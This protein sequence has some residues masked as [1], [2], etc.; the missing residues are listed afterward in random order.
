MRHNRPRTDAERH[1]DAL[2]EAGK[3]RRHLK[4]QRFADEFD[5]TAMLTAVK[6]VRCFDPNRGIP[7][8]TYVIASVLK[9]MRT[10]H[11]KLRL[12]GFRAKPIGTPIVLRI[13]ETHEAKSNDQLDV[14]DLLQHVHEPDRQD[15]LDH[16]FG[17]KTLQEIAEAHGV[18]RQWIHA[19]IQRA[20]RRMR[21]VAAGRMAYGTRSEPLQWSPT[22]DRNKQGG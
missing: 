14:K 21:E 3:A 1:V 2:I 8:R 4:D 7:L 20:L 22:F 16:F 9:E 13:D 18:A 6:A 15:V 5:C 12:R 17:G 10:T 19:R 11:R